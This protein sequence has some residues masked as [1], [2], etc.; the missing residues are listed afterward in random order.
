MPSDVAGF[1]KKLQAQGAKKEEEFDALF[2]TYEVMHTSIFCDSYICA[3]V[4]TTN[5]AAVVDGMPPTPEKQ[6]I[7]NRAGYYLCVDSNTGLC[8]R[9]PLFF[10]PDDLTL[11]R[12]NTLLLFFVLFFLFRQQSKYPELAAEFKRRMSGQL[13]E[14]WKDKL[15]KFTPEV[16]GSIP[17]KCTIH[18]C[19]FCCFFSCACMRACM[20]ASEANSCCRY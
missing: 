14:G 2:A 16:R 18:A 13:P 12:T 20:R 19:C 6:S 4:A 17:T 11:R 7:E 3:T 9:H 10:D 5:R 1:Y 15:P 8:R